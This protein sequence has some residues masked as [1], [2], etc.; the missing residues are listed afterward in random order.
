ML[1]AL[2]CRG[3][4][5]DGAYRWRTRDD[6]ADRRP[7]RC[8]S[9]LHKP[10]NI[11]LARILFVV[12]IITIQLNLSPLG[13]NNC[14]YNLCV[15]FCFITVSKQAVFRQTWQFQ[16]ETSPFLS[17]GTRRQSPWM[18]IN[19]R[20]NLQ[21]FRWRRERRLY[22][23]ISE[24]N[25]NITNP[26]NFMIGV[27]TM[28]AGLNGSSGATAASSQGRTAI[29]NYKFC[30]GKRVGVWNPKLLVGHKS[31]S[32]GLQPP[33]TGSVSGISTAD[34]EGAWLT[35]RLD[36]PSQHA[37]GTKRSDDK[38]IIPQL[39]VCGFRVSRAPI[40]TTFEFKGWN[41]GGAHL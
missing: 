10:F 35:R 21:S 2:W 20:N 22:N 18:N 7:T 26:F 41:R 38:Q 32:V 6:D 23:F 39:I 19:A 25:R 13:F 3:W 31:A 24:C 11:V 1:I 15:V 40:T 17:K 5:T 4:K 27:I 34:L 8:C 16:S 12:W 30:Y 28:G 33:I 14:I 37:P 29:P 9:C 36:S